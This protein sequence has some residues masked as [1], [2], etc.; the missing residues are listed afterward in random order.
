MGGYFMWFHHPPE[1]WVELIPMDP[2]DTAEQIHVGP[3]GHPAVLQEVP[4]LRYDP[5]LPSMRTETR[6]PDP[7]ADD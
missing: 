1:G 6:R 5:L 7:E 2:W 4:V 3:K